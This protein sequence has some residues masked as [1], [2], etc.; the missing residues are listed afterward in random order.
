MC[1]IIHKFFS[2]ATAQ[3][4]Q[5]KKLRCSYLIY[6]PYSTFFLC[7][8]IH[9][10]YSPYI[11]PGPGSNPELLLHSEVIMP[12]TPFVRTSSLVLISHHLSVLKHTGYFVQV[13]PLSDILLLDSGYASPGGFTQMH[14][15]QE[16]NGICSWLVMLTLINL[17]WVVCTKFSS[18]KLTI[19]IL[20]VV[21]FLHWD[22]AVAPFPIKF[23]PS[24]SGIHQRLS[25]QLLPC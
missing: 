11:L 19:F 3:I 25:L 7:Q 22:H 21:S 23:P 1:I 12:L 6:K 9:C 18:E 13:S 10:S 8:D 15:L 2:I 5:L 20:C 17:M 14:S 16:E 24:S 4:I